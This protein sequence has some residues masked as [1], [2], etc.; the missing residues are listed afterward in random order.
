MIAKVRDLV[1]RNLL[2]KVISLLTA[3]VLWLVVMN[4]QNPSIENNYTIPIIVEDVPSG[5]K[6]TYSDDHVRIRV[7]GPRA[8]FVD[9]DSSDFKARLSLA[10]LKEGSHDV[11]VEVICPQG[12]DLLEATPPAITVMMDP[13][14]EKQYRT[15]LT[16]TGAPANGKTVADIEKDNAMAT[17]VGP[18]SAVDTVESVVGYIGLTGNEEDFDLTV[19]LKALDEDGNEVGNVR[20]HPASTQV[21]VTLARGLSKKVVK[22]N[23]VLGNA[24]PGYEVRSVMAVP[25]QVEIAGD[26]KV[27]S[28]LTSISTETI[29]L[30]STD[31]IKRTARLRLPAGVT[32][33]N[34]E[35]VVSVDIEPVG[36][37][38]QAADQAAKSD[39][40]S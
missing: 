36:K 10:N 20:I 13:F 35:V 29:P 32:I 7:K 40:K 16:V 19:P 11:K 5:Y 21:H 26:E 25:A 12:F 24:A 27:I 34:P 23:P 30:E 3:I 1:Q 18:K 8:N 14:T 4:D 15:T 38:P 17:V 28:K 37:K 39:D 33:T 2:V 22:V 6:I 31:D 9:H